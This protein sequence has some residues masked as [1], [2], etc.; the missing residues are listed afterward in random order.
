M[1]S[2]SR[3]KRLISAA[4][5]YL[6]L[7]MPKHALASLDQISGGREVQFSIHCL[8]GF[9]L[10]DLKRHDE[11]LR[12]F[13]WALTEDPDSADVLLAMAWCYKRTDQLDQAIS[14][15]EEAYRVSP[16]E[17]IVLYNLACYWALAGNKTQ[18]LSWL[19]RALRMDRKL[20]KLIPEESDFDCLRHDP[21]FEMIVSAGA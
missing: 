2:G 20:L 10:R 16:R 12:C 3:N 4:E 19:G 7:E 18:A 1:A 11:A 15:M 8:R 9:A 14:I 5:G 13:E 17:S 21:D 6:M